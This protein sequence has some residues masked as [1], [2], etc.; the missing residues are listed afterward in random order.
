MGWVA[1]SLRFHSECSRTNN[2]CMTC[3]T[4]DAEGTLKS[5][6][7]QTESNSFEELFTDGGQFSLKNEQISER[8]SRKRERDRGMSK[9]TVREARCTTVNDNPKERTRNRLIV[10][11]QTKRNQIAYLKERP[12]PFPSKSIVPFPILFFNHVVSDLDC[13]LSKKVEWKERNTVFRDKYLLGFSSTPSGWFNPNP[14]QLQLLSKSSPTFF[15]LAFRVIP[16]GNLSFSRDFLW[17]S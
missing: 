11:P 2:S 9:Q 14:T 1:T 5:Q 4:S 6:V 10:F 12:E 13:A 16:C 3:P 15:C 8:R 17:K 7:E